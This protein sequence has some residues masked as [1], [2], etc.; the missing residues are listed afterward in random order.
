[1]QRKENFALNNGSYW[2]KPTY[3]SVQKMRHINQ[4]S[5]VRS[6]LK[7]LSCTIFTWQTLGVL[8]ADVSL[9]L[10]ENQL[11]SAEFLTLVQST[12]KPYMYSSWGR[13]KIGVDLDS[14]FRNLVSKVPK[15]HIFWEGHKRLKKSHSL[16]TF[17]IIIKF[18]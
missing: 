1:M 10:K 7:R 8:L 6:F 5:K 4:I 12:F 11:K 2:S 3:I 9:C 15:V 16:L 18:K 14:Y 13:C 17:S